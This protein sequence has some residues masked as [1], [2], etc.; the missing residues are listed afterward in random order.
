MTI[1]FLGLKSCRS[2]SSIVLPA[3]S[4]S[5]SIYHL[6]RMVKMGMIINML[7][8]DTVLIG[9]R[10]VDVG[11]TEAWDPGFGDYM[12][13][14][15][16]YLPKNVDHN[17]GN[18]IGVGVCQLGAHNGQR[19]TASGAYLSF[20]PSN[21]TIMTDATITKIIT[22]G[23]KAVGVD[24]DGK[25][26]SSISTLFKIVQ[27]EGWLYHSTRKRR[28]LSRSR[29]N[30]YTE[31]IAPI[32]HWPGKRSSRPEHSGCPRSPWRWQKSPGPP[33][34]AARDRAEA[35]KSSSNIVY[36]LTSST[37][38]STQRM[39]EQSVRSA[40]WLLSTS[41][42]SIS[43]KWQYSCLARVWRLRQ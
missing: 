29:G 18:P 12:R 11:V 40:F 26:R 33:L 8:Q 5:L 22:E 36:R 1:V 28:D 3:T 41:D 38:G 27:R 17:S 31:V 4:R 6:P 7:H 20:H 15:Y 21:L 19:V 13:N 30:R 37:G 34:P 25:Q 35:R 24:V 9:N 2:K 10:P 39:A 16:H 32:W 42:D 14:S 23:K 43:Q